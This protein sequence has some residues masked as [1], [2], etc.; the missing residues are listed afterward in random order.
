MKSNLE[1]TVEDKF[2]RIA[3]YLNHQLS[4]E[5]QDRF[6][7]EYTSSPEFRKEVDASRSIWEQ[8]ELLKKQSQFDTPQNWYQLQR[9]MHRASALLR[10]WNGIRTTAAILLIPLGLTITYLLANRDNKG[11]LPLTEEMIKVTSAPGLVSQITLPDSTLVWLNSGA[12][13]TYP[14]RFTSARRNVTLSGEAYFKVKSDSAHRFDVDIPGLM[15]VSAYGTEFNVSAYSDDSTIEAILAK[16]HIEVNAPDASPQKLEVAQQATLNK[17]T[18]RIKV[19]NCNLSDKLAWIEGKI[20]FRRANINEIVKRLSRHYNVDFAIQG[21]NLNSYEF[22]ATFSDETLPEILSILQKTAPMRYYI[23]EARK[24][25]D[26]TYT[27]RKVTLI[28][29]K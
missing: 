23:N 10:T 16:G 15:I 4:E 29:D 12:S 5:E 17:T 20:I 25:N 22:S 21:S 19:N 9:R 2:N 3:A 26:Q 18:G 24:Q 11:I 27:R 8:T 14:R 13:L 7:Q 6:E 1:N 28:L